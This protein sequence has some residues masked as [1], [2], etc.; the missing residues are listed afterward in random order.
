VPASPLALPFAK[1]LNGDMRLTGVLV[2]FWLGLSFSAVSPCLPVGEGDGALDYLNALREQAGLPPLRSNAAL[3]RAAEDHARY[4]SRHGGNPHRQ[5]P[6]R[7][8]F[9][10]RTADDRAVAAGY[11]SRAV[12]ENVSRGQRDSSRSIDDLMS[13]IYHRLGF[14][15]GAMTEIGI[16][17]ALGGS[18]PSRSYVYLMGNQYLAQLCAG[19][20]ANNAAGGFP[21]GY[22]DQV[23]DSARKVDAAQWD[24]ATRRPERGSYEVVLWP[25]RGSDH[26]LPAFYD[27]IPDPLPRHKVSGYPLSVQ[28]NPL[29]FPEAIH[30]RR[31]ELWDAEAGRKL[32]LIEL[33][34]QGN[35]PNQKLTAQQFVLFPLDRLL[36]GHPYRAEFEY[37]Y[38]GQTHTLRWDFSTRSLPYPVT[39]VAASG[40][41]YAIA[42][43]ETSAIVIVPMLGR[44]LYRDV[45]WKTPKGMQVNVDW[46][47]DNTLLV[48]L[49]GKPCAKV[50]FR[51][52]NGFHLTLLEAAAKGPG[53]GCGAALG[54]AAGPSLQ[55][56]PNR[57]DTGLSTGPVSPAN[58]IQ[59]KGELFTVRS[60]SRYVFAVKPSMVYPTLGKIR[61]RSSAGARADVESLDENRI[62][63]R[64]TGEAGEA[65]IFDLG[66]GRY[67]KVV[68]MP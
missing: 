64:V 22:Y 16:G 33:L 30:V 11:P 58:T 6:G 31:F 67:F 24:A 45:R 29:S 42:S 43:G 40:G 25:P 32:A 5:Q 46:E 20:A 23:C 68:L 4:L 19:G 2:I 57:G 55:H 54:A 21:D 65:V 47:D 34:Q 15:D 1:G 44:E 39:R 62:A 63:V 50:D 60:G 28:F 56:S 52:T 59:G 10:G 9:T 3:Q 49:R 26:V 37:E 61:V 8:G 36:W 17:Q 66:D 48:K 14:L 53:G 41:T 35:D 18:R 7:S 12:S 51:F 13:A 27:E 38:Q